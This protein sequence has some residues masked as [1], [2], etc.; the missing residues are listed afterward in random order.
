MRYMRLIAIVAA[1]LAGTPAAFADTLLVDSIQA[2]ASVKTPVRA[3]SMTSVS[4]QFGEPQ[5]RAG[6]V[7]DP[8]IS[9]WDYGSFIVYFERDR[10]IHSVVKSH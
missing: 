2:N 6:P 9:Q 8:P 10:V 5:H 1:M 4:Q 7:G 3:S